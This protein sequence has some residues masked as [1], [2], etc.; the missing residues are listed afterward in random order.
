MIRAIFAGRM[1][2]ARFEDKLVFGCFGETH[3][4]CIYSQKLQLWEVVSIFIARSLFM[5]LFITACR[6]T[7]STLS[8]LHS[9]FLD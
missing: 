2:R 1:Y 8:E 7:I 3:G 6:F 5:V 4:H 9:V